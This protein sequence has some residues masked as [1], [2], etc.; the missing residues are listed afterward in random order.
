MKL[1]SS[2][3]P[4]RTGEDQETQRQKGT[5]KQRSRERKRQEK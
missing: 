4:K 2:T 1:I 5:Q 3:M